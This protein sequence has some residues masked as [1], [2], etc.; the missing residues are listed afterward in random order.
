MERNSNLSWGVQEMEDRT[1]KYDVFISYSHAD[2]DNAV[3]GYLQKALE[4]YRIPREIQ[5]KTGREKIS[6]VFRD[7]EELSVSADLEKEIREQIEQSEYLIVVCTSSAVQSEWVTK[8]INTFL[9][10][11]DRTKII[12]VLAEGNP[13]NSF[14]A[15]LLDQYE[16]GAA[17]IK[18][19]TKKIVLKNA[20][21]ELPRIVAPLLGC[22]YAELV[23]RQKVYQTR[24]AV[25]VVSGIAILSAAVGSGALI[26]RQQIKENYW[27]SLLNQTKYLVREAKLQLQDDQSILAL[28]LALAALP[29]KDVDRPVTAEAEHVLMQSLYAY[30]PPG[31]VFTANTWQYSANNTIVKFCISEDQ[32]LLFARDASNTVYIWN[33]QGE[34]QCVFSKQYDAMWFFD[35]EMLPIG[36][37][38]L[39][40]TDATLICINGKTGKTKWELNSSDLNLSGL[41]IEGGEY[42]KGQDK[43]ILRT[44]DSLLIITGENGEIVEEIELEKNED[45]EYMH[46]SYSPEKVRASENGD[47]LAID[48]LIDTNRHTVLLYSMKSHDYKETGLEYY[49]ITD[50]CVA[51][52]RVLVSGFTEYEY[53]TGPSSSDSFK[54]QKS[55]TCAVDA[56]TG[57]TLWENHSDIYQP[58]DKTNLLVSDIVCDDG[59]KRKV[60]SRTCSNV[61][62]FLDFNDGKVIAC[63]ETDSPVISLKDIWDDNRFCYILN[64]G[65]QTVMSAD[66]SM[67]KDR[68]TFVMRDQ[69][70][71]DIK[72]AVAFHQGADEFE[73]VLKNDSSS[74]LFYEDF[75]YDSNLKMIDPGT[76]SE[77]LIDD[78]LILEDNA[79][80]MRYDDSSEG[81]LM[82]LDLAEKKISQRIPLPG[83]TDDYRMISDRSDSGHVYLVRVLD[84]DKDGKSIEL[85]VV[86]LESG[87]KKLHKISVDEEHHIYLSDLECEVAGNR[88]CYSFSNSDK[89][90][91]VFSCYDLTKRTQDE[92][93]LPKSI[94]GQ[95]EE[96][97]EVSSWFNE[98]ATQA[99]I[100]L[101][102]GK[103]E[104]NKYM[105]TDLSTDEVTQI[106]LPFEPN[107]IIW[108]EDGSFCGTVDHGN[109]NLWD[110]TTQ[111]TRTVTNAGQTVEYAVSHEDKVY[112]LTDTHELY[113]Y[114]NTED[115][116]TGQTDLDEELSYNTPREQWLFVG[117]ELVITRHE[118]THI[119]DLSEM[120]EKTTVYYSQGYCPDEDYF[121]VSL[122]DVNSQKQILGY[123]ERY[124]LDEL[125][126]MGYERIKENPME[127]KLKNQYGIS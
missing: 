84:Q 118:I 14:P 17:D 73:L 21:R 45:A 11:H 34:R 10:S 91:R 55:L 20:K 63:Y 112:Y 85:T 127:E 38:L 64:N 75:Y 48:V 90:K 68:N 81:E 57:K 3:A 125:I 104:T 18:G 41:K 15:P 13:Q 87:K 60:V 111:K 51:D 24:K 106:E 77:Y 94:A 39:L 12:P 113:R 67:D 22:S 35:I 66:N 47:L 54:K 4:R 103:E 5:K 65:K 31:A 16:H 25:A 46:D 97:T 62:Q 119:V 52:D 8:E 122:F 93:V 123:Y 9:E 108:N 58:V 78:A 49:E 6:R 88:L 76:E 42:L 2:L 56:G 40:G 121:I 107:R 101:S 116:I 98:N 70:T 59:T 114:D 79:C 83:G 82:I 30:Y 95:L 80:L 126:S 44:Y 61:V 43:V 105:L 72:D 23:Q 27:N 92:Y 109:L 32:S 53:L 115:R 26:Q 124:S 102:A 99:L 33:L 50:L 100:C 89:K 37:D 1:Y 36:N 69:Y 110:S 86:N 74:I 19:E 96:D 28:Q 29:S 7:K 117:D 71:K 120:K